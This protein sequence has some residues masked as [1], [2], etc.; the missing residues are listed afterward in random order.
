[1]Y[2]PVGDIT[3]FL[4][5]DDF[6]G[7]MSQRFAAGDRYK[8]I[9]LASG[10]ADVLGAE[11]ELGIELATNALREGSAGASGGSG[12]GGLLG[13]LNHPKV[14]E[15]GSDLLKGLFD[16]GSA[17]VVTDFTSLGMGGIEG[18]VPSAFDATGLFGGL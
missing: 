1:M 10:I 14:Y 12:A 8:D 13:G 3:D 18:S 6:Y 16:S 5:G 4:D 17:D 15:T 7:E 2:V 9:Y 11:T